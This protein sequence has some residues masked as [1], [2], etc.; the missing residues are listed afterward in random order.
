MERAI[1]SRMTRK[2]PQISAVYKALWDFVRSENGA[3][4]GNETRLQPIETSA[5]AALQRK[6]WP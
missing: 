6:M 4:K 2:I 1:T 5:N 3:V